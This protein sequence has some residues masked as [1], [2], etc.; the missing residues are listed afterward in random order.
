VRE[1]SILGCYY[2]SARPG[3]DI[4]MLVDLYRDGRLRPEV[5]LDHTI[6]LDEIEQ[7]FARMRM[8]EAGR[9]IIRL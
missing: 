4:P 1:K 6:G 9:T 7:A 8:G 5:T 2:G 3:L